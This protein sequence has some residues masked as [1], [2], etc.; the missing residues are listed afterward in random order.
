MKNINVGIA[1]DHS[2]FREGIRMI[3]EEMLDITLCLEA[4]SGEDLLAQLEHIRPDVVLLDL[5]MKGMSGIDVLKTIRENNSI[6]KVIILSLHTESRMI[7]HLMK[8]GANGYLIKDTKKN[9]LE[10]AIRE[11]YEKGVAFNE[12]MANSLLSDLRGKSKKVTLSVA[13]STRE[14]EVLELICQEYTTHAIAEKLFISERT[15]EGHRKNLCAKMDV[16]NSVGLVK[17]AIALN[18]IELS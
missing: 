1:D 7:S 6:L 18:L 2:L 16:K 15:V 17:K 5:E 12:Q 9:E 8:L 13:L 11:V 14:K 4:T 10:T 3:I